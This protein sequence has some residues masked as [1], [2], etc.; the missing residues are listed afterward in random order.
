MHFAI[1]WN[2]NENFPTNEIA[3][4]EMNQ[5]LLLSSWVRPMPNFYVIHVNSIEQYDVI[6]DGLLAIAM[7][8]P[9]VSAII[10]PPMMG[11]TYGGR[12][13]SDIWNQ[14]NARSK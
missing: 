5:F 10:T 12:L 14:L 1:H 11:G 9:Q 4:Q 8:Y 13:P 6:S 7:K 2:F 3:T